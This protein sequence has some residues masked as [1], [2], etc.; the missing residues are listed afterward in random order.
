MESRA[1]TEEAFSENL[2]VAEEDMDRYLIE[3]PHT[4]SE[5]L[6][7][8]KQIN[9][10]G[11]LQNFD[12]G[13]EAGIHAGWAIIEAENEEQAHL[14]VPPLVRRRARITKLNKFDAIAIEHY[15]KQEAAAPL[16]NLLGESRTRVGVREAPTPS[17]RRQASCG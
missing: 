2:F 15:E 8:I 6:A 3:T 13:C 16:Q 1:W 4:G 7:L 9:A 12:W 11:Y 10:Q 17:Q 5:C 14:A